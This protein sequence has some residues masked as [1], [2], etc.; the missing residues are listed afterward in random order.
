MIVV[1]RLSIKSGG[2]ILLRTL[3]SVQKEFATQASGSLMLASLLQE[4]HR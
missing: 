2:L 3:S 4:T 1:T